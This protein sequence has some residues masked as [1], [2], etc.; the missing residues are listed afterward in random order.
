MKVTLPVDIYAPKEKK[1]RASKQIISTPPPRSHSCKSKRINLLQKYNFNEEED[2]SQDE[3]YIMVDMDNNSHEDS[4][5]NLSGAES[6]I[7]EVDEDEEKINTTSSEK[8]SKML[9]S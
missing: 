1:T 9:L 4:D 2:D 6:D 5:Y 8:I 3:D 7:T